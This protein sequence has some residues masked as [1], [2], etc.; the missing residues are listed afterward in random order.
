[1]NGVRKEWLYEYVKLKRSVV[2]HSHKDF[3]ALVEKCYN[4]S[5]IYYFK[6]ILQDTT[7]RFNEKQFKNNL[8][9]C[10]KD[11]EMWVYEKTDHLYYCNGVRHP[12]NNL[13]ST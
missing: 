7:F 1:M 5:S 2:P 13:P 4:N 9:F 11:R 3:Y 6:C 12:K 10:R 8:K